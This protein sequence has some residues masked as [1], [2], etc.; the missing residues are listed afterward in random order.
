MPPEGRYGGLSKVDA[1]KGVGARVPATARKV[2]SEKTF[3]FEKITV[4]IDS[5]SANRLSYGLG[6]H[7]GGLNGGIL[8]T[9]GAW[10]YVVVLW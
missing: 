10:M 8:Q 3:P 4:A 1:D 5:A 2:S 9:W 6:L 7:G